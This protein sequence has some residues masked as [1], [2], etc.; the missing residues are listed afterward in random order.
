MFDAFPCHRLLSYPFAGA[1]QR[2]NVR[3]PGGSGR[4]LGVPRGR[5]SPS[6][7]RGGRARGDARGGD[8]VAGGLGASIHRLHGNEDAPGE[9]Y[10]ALQSRSK[11]KTEL[12]M[13]SW[14]FRQSEQRAQWHS[15]LN[16]L[17][18]LQPFEP[19][20]PMNYL[21]RCIRSPFSP[22]C[23]RQNTFRHLTCCFDAGYTAL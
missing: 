19:S 11:P 7:D 9:W 4:P 16:S 20:I 18:K 23:F 1:S 15:S 21:A 10:I 8:P 12:V 6:A 14:W 22:G 5:G 2:R 13:V 3:V 17:V